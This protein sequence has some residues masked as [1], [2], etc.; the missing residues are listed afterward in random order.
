MTVI[1]D[2]LPGLGRD[3]VEE[4]LEIE[5]GTKAILFWKVATISAL[6][7]RHTFLKKKCHRQS[8]LK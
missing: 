7:T 6:I 2:F 1:E 8:Q 3:T 4:R 5:G